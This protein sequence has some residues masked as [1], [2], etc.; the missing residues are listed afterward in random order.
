MS[1]VSVSP[2]G[3]HVYAAGEKDIALAV[4]SR[5][6]ST[7]DLTFVERIKDG[8]NGVDGLHAVR[9][10]AVSHDGKNVYAA[11]YWDDSVAV[12]SRDASTGS[13]TFVEVHEGGYGKSGGDG[14]YHAVSVVVSPDG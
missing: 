11:G 10:V 8:V 2:D 12:F 1:S 14:L 4:L 6:S 9:S 7:G 3:K 5:D 13:L